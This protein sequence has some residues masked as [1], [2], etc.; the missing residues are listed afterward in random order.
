MKK[1]EWSVLV[2][3][4]GNNELEPEMWK[5]KSDLEKIGSSDEIN[6]VT[7]IARESQEILDIIRPND[8]VKYSEEKWIGVRRYYI[9]R[10]GSILIEKLKDV[11]MA[12][13]KSLYNFIEWGIKSYP[14]KRYMVIVAGHGFT[15]AALSDLSLNNPH[16]MGVYEMCSVFNLINKNLGI[17]IEVLVLDICNMNNIELVY[18]LGKNEKIATNYLLTF[19]ESGPLEGI[20]YDKMMRVLQEKSIIETKLLL[21]DIIRYIDED[22]VAISVNHSKLVKIKKMFNILGKMKLQEKNHKTTNEN[23][24]LYN[25]YRN[26]INKELNDIILDYKLLQMKPPVINVIDSSVYSLQNYQAFMKFYNKLSFSKNNY[27][28]NVVAGKGLEYPLNINRSIMEEY[29]LTYNNIFAFIK[30][31][32]G[33]ISNDEIKERVVRLCNYK[34]WKYI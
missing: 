11:N 34:G 13:F 28:A 16:T 32:N 22:L 27:W 2:Y 29:V 23:I 9:T 5:S 10:E 15:V 30:I 1:K 21:K 33:N 20:P 31:F 7:Q 12:S 18:E 4:N 19:I 6:I 3:L 25:K 8:S 26:E 14:A 24:K 17:N